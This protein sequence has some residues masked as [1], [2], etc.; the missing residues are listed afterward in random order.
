V[1]FGALIAT[2]RNPQAI[3]RRVAQIN[4]S[5]LSAHYCSKGDDGDWYGCSRHFAARCV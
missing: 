5:A 1:E 4:T 2:P 3:I